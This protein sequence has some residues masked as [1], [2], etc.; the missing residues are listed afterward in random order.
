MARLPTPGSDAGNWGDILNDFLSQV[1]KA[2]GTLKDDTVGS[3]QLVDDAVGVAQLANSSVQTV[4][5]ADSSVTTLKLADASVTSAKLAPGVLAGATVAD[6]SITTVKLAD[7]AVTNVKVDAATRAS[8]S[9]ADS[10]SQPGHAHAIADVTNLQTTLDGKQPTGSYVP[11]SRT[12]AG[13]P[14]T[15]DITMTPADIG[16]ATTAQGAKAD[17]AVQLGGDIA[18]TALNPLVAGING[19]SVTGTA[20]ADNILISS[21]S[22]H[23]SWQPIP[24]SGSSPVIAY[25]GTS[26][27]LRSTATSS[28]TTPVTWV[29]TVAPDVG[30]GYALVGID[31]WINSAGV[32]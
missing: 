3:A 9:K 18:G 25:S 15:S 6:G 1:H 20:A 19:V 7:D 14:L 21:D 31:L 27:A 2:D 17:S 4:A 26:Y 23:A 32:V 28:S 10:A 24:V 30:N 29:G 13:Y 5:L 16:A 12:V 11:S 22:T 8:L